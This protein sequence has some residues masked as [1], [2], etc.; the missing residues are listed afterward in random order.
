MSRGNCDMSDRARRAWLDQTI[1]TSCLSKKSSVLA[2]Q[3]SYYRME[4]ISFRRS[5]KSKVLSCIY[6]TINIFKRRPVHE[7]WLERPKRH[8]ENLTVRNAWTI[9]ANPLAV[10]VENCPTFPKQPYKH[11]QLFTITEVFSQSRLTD[12]PTK[13]NEI[14]QLPDVPSVAVN[15]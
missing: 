6:L 12:Q 4:W 7:T 15:Q 9:T 14:R 2:F 10:L 11:L 3:R 13:E 1:L 5:T 8:N